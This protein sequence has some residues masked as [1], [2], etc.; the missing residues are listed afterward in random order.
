MNKTKSFFF[1]F[2]VGGAIGSVIALLYAPKSGKNLRNDI[3]RKT[4]EII[5]EGRKKTT[6]T[7]NGAKEK[8]ESTIENANDYLNE[9]MEKVA[10]KSEKVKNA[11]KSGMN[12]YSDERKSGDNQ[13][14][15]H[16][17]DYDNSNNQIT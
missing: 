1:S 15:T 3:S 10:R 13:S 5:E 2:L 17:E 14:S 8:V 6:K 4:N 7:W 16:K 9:G 12:A 11:V